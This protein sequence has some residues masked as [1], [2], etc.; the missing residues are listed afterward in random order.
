M[1]KK[2]YKLAECASPGCVKSKKGPSS[3]NGKTAAAPETKY[4]QQ[5]EDTR[6]GSDSGAGY[7]KPDSMSESDMAK[8]ER[9][10]GVPGQ[11]VR[12]VNKGKGPKQVDE[13]SYRKS[14]GK[15]LLAR[16]AK[17]SSSASTSGGDE[18]D[19]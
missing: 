19:E 16:K 7:S 11:R 8:V 17:P 12:M 3:G 1:A 6:P 2:K 9:E 18:D 4:Q 10:E 5:Y 14:K 13:K 15:V